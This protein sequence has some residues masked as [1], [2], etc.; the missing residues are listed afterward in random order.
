MRT[1]TQIVHTNPRAVGCKLAARGMKDIY[2]Y[3][4]DRGYIYGYNG[5]TEAA[6]PENEF[7]SR[8]GIQV[9]GKV[10]SK[11]PRQK[12]LPNY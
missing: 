7:T 3:D 5:Y 9:V 1:G 6:D 12:V 4:A 11:G 10:T 8:Y 2:L